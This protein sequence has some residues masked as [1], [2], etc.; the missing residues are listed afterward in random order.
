M[1]S[2]GSYKKLRRASQNNDGLH[3]RA[4]V[5]FGGFIVG[6]RSGFAG[7]APDGT[8]YYGNQFLNGSSIPG[9]SPDRRNNVEGFY[10]PEPMPGMY[11]V[12]IT[13]FRVSEDA[14]TDTAEIDQDFSLVIAGDLAIESEQNLICLEGSEPT[15]LPAGESF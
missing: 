7:H 3:G 14:R 5:A 8:V 9:S 13:A 6:E 10:L 1:E 11:T 4:R 2:G 12:S 15:P